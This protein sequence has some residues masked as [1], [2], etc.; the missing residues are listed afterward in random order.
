MFNINIALYVL[1]VNGFPR[2]KQPAI[3]PAALIIDMIIVPFSDKRLL[4]STMTGHRYP[5][6]IPLITD[7]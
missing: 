7:R 2:K 4:K 5:A 3:W 6:R 1:A